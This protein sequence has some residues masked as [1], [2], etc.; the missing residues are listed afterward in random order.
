M[1]NVRTRSWHA[2]GVGG[3]HGDE[4][5]LIRGVVPK[6]GA[7]LF[8]IGERI[9]ALSGTVLKEARLSPAGVRTVR[10]VVLA[11]ARLAE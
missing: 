8:F 5:V 10:R 7:R 1:P 6:P 4:R 2:C 3:R 9:F 11:P